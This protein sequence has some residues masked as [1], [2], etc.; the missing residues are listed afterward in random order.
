MAEENVAGATETPEQK[1]TVKT[2]AELNAGSGQTDYEKLI[3]E[4]NAKI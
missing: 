4:Q 2:Q 1:E 3:A